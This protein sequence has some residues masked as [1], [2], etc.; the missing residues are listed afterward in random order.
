MKTRNV[1]RNSEVK[2]RDL[3]GRPKHTWNEMLHTVNGGRDCES[4]YL[5]FMVRD[6]DE[7]RILWDCGHDFTGLIMSGKSLE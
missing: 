4:F 3:F 7:R 5:I 1:V 2:R 6:R